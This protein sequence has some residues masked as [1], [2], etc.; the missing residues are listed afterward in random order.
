MRRVIHVSDVTG[1][2]GQARLDHYNKWLMDPARPFTS[3][4]PGYPGDSE[5]NSKVLTETVAVNEEASIIN[6]LTKEKTMSK[7]EAAIEIVKANPEKKVA[8]D[9]IVETLGVTRANAFVYWSKAMKGMCETPVNKE[10]K[11]SVKTEKS[12]R[13]TNPVTGTTPAKA[14]AKLKEIDAVIAG[15]KASGASVASPF[16]VAV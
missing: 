10:A 3:A 11:A 7:L 13:K 8:L 1:K 6:V 15:L 2:E 14:A 12:T 5:E 4:Y 9:V 16:P